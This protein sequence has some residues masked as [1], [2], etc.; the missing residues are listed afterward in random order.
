MFAFEDRPPPS[1]PRRTWVTALA[2]S[3]GLLLFSVW[4]LPPAWYVPV[5]L[6]ATIGLLLLA[7]RINLTRSELGLERERVSLGMRWGMAAALVVGAVVVAGAAIPA[8]RPLFDDARTAGI[9]PGLL[10]YRALVRIP[11]GTVLLEEVAFRSVLLAAW[12]RAASLPVAV[13]GSSV[14]FGL[15]HVRPAIDLLVEN[16]LAA[17]GPARVLAVLGAVAGTT[18][19]GIAFCWLRIRSGSLLAPVLAHLTA[20]SLATV[21]SY[22]V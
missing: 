10:A 12:R 6:L 14:I 16:D 13:V 22:L 11:F 20:N 7:R 15:W 1:R 9:G 19:A 5:N 3:V 17:D 2:I 8:S 4:G 21:L 18:V